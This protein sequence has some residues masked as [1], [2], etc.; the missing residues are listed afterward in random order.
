LANDK[1]KASAI[2]RVNEN[3][4][5]KEKD[6]HEI[7]DSLKK[8]IGVYST[9]LNY[10]SGKVEVI[11]DPEKLTLDEIKEKIRSK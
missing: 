2:L 3:H 8:L 9:R 10:V 6:L 7:E 1:P 5:L 4:N 11:Y